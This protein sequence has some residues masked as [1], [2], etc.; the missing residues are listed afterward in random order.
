MR[1]YS[2]SLLD[3]TRS[4]RSARSGQS[5]IPPIFEYRSR[6]NWTEIP[7]HENR[8]GILRLVGRS[9]SNSPLC[10]GQR[11]RF[12]WVQSLLTSRY[13][14]SWHEPAIRAAGSGPRPFAEGIHSRFAGAPVLAGKLSWA[15][16]RPRLPVRPAAFIYDAGV[17]RPAGTRIG[18]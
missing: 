15:V 18:Y 13:P 10:P 3:A 16:P 9:C 7:S 1:I 5:R 6:P 14:I 12:W 11:R 17:V 8:V 4:L 2:R